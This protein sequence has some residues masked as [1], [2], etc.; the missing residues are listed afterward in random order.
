[1]RHNDSPPC[2]TG[3]ASAQRTSEP[4]ALPRPTSPGN[5]ASPCKRYPSSS[6]AL[7][8]P[9]SIESTGFARCWAWNWCCRKRP[10]ASPTPAASQRGDHGQ[11]TGAGYLDERHARRRMGMPQERGRPAHLRA[12]V[13]QF[14]RR[15]PCPPR[16]LTQAMVEYVH[17]EPMKTVAGPAKGFSGRLVRR[18][19]YRRLG[20]GEA[21]G[22]RT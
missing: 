17:P 21:A 9:R 2:A 4:G 6:A 18:R 14:T 12:Q 10:A 3:R 11:H 13:D 19:G 22:E 5:W 7:T 20:R 8:R 16:A 15:T 1:M